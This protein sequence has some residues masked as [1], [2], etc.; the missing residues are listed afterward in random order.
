MKILKQGNLKG[1]HKK[2]I[3][4]TPNGTSFIELPLEINANNIGKTL[5]QILVN[6]DNYNYVLTLNAIM[7]STNPVKETFHINFTQKGKVELKK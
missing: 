6:K 3:I 4:I 7:E 5:F 1:N 2:S